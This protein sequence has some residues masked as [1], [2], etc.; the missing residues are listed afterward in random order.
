MKEYFV[1]N[2]QEDEDGCVLYPANAIIDKTKKND[3]EENS[4][5]S[6]TKKRPLL[7]K[8]IITKKLLS[9]LR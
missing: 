9:R 8:R 4:R 5:D 2:N 7:V 6:K 3:L 1:V